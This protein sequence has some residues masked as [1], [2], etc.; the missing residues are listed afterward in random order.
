MFKLQNDLDSINKIARSYSITIS[1]DE[2]VAQSSRSPVILISLQDK[3]EQNIGTYRF[4]DQQSRIEFNSGDNLHAFF[5]FADLNQDFIYQKTEPFSLVKIQPASLTEKHTQSQSTMKLSYSGQENGPV[6]DFLVGV[7]FSKF[8]QIF[9]LH[10][11]VGTVTSIDSP[12][13]TIEHGRTGMW[14]PFTF[15][16]NGGFG[17]HMLQKYDPDKIPVLFVH[18]MGDGPL[19]FKPLINKLDTSKYQA[20]VYSYPTAYRLQNT[21]SGLSALM[22]SLHYQYRFTQL[23]I[24]AHSMGGLISKAYINE[25]S[26]KEDCSYLSSF[27]TIST[28]WLGHHG[29]QSG[30]TYSPVVMPSWIDMSPD[31][32]FLADLFNQPLTVNLQYNLLFTF[33][34][35][36]KFSRESSDGVISLHSQLRRQAQNSA[37]KI[38][39]YDQTHT[40]IFYSEI[41]SGDLFKLFTLSEQP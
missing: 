8:T 20:W 37:F 22:K 29:A 34:T 24:V 11:N 7:H 15:L 27:T 41:M 18:G 12:L 1:F 5:A 40:S 19:R 36:K 38:K 9:G 3:A 32:Q 21:A 28:P 25:C 14:E 30:V 33:K 16:K 31:S 23:H 17:V 39:G 2:A 13:F 6:P 35:G 4:I 10:I 26:A